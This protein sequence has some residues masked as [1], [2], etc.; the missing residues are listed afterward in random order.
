[1][2]LDTPPMVVAIEH[3]DKKVRSLAVCAVGCRRRRRVLGAEERDAEV[4]VQ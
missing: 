4:Q 3:Q 1:M 2:A